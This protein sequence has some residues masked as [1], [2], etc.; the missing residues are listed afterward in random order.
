MPKRVE[1]GLFL[2]TVSICLI[3]IG[4]TYLY[5]VI[6][7]RPSDAGAHSPQTLQEV[8]ADLVYV[9][10]TTLQ[11]GIPSDHG[12][13]ELA[14]PKHLESGEAY[15]F[16]RRLDA[17]VLYYLAFK[18]RLRNAGFTIT[19]APESDRDLVHLVFGG[20]LVKIEFRRGHIR[21]SVYNTLDPRIASDAGLSARML[22]E[23]F[24][25]TLSK[26]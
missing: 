4:L 16:H 12:T 23:D 24:V 6:W 20:P 15:I 8:F 3:I 11:D 21:G 17:G 2:N 19:L 5:S 9:G 25:L 10:T 7:A 18:K 22:P 1:R 13:I 14:L 26:I